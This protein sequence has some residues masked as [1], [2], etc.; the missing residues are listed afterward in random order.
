MT[1]DKPFTVCE[2]CGSPKLEDESLSLVLMFKTPEDRKEFA[3]LVGQE[4]GMVSYNI[5]E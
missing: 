2:H 3:E 4:L 1:T 5:D